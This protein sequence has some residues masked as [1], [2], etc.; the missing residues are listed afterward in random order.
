MN[1]V[2]TKLLNV[3]TMVRL[4]SL[5]T[6]SLPLTPLIHSHFGFY[7]PRPDIDASVEV[8]EIGQA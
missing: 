2:N 5:L 3:A 4:N 7:F 6:Y 1:F 8:V